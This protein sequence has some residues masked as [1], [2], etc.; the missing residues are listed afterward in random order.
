MIYPRL[1]YKFNVV[2]P[3][4]LKLYHCALFISSD[5]F[6]LFLIYGEMKTLKEGTRH[7]VLTARLFLTCICWGIFVPSHYKNQHQDL[8]LL[9][10]LNAMHMLNIG[11]ACTNRE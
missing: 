8:H 11:L 3:Q 5:T 1:R 9:R 6:V 10:L 2:A 4:I 7:G